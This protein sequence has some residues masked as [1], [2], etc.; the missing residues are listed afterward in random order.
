MNN[1][2]YDYPLTRNVFC[3]YYHTSLILNM[4]FF[5]NFSIR[6]LDSWIYT[7]SILNV[8][9]QELFDQEEYISVLFSSTELLLLWSQWR[10]SYRT[11]TNDYISGDKSRYIETNITRG[12]S[13][14]SPS[15]LQWVLHNTLG[16]NKRTW[17]QASKSN[18][19]HWKWFKRS[20]V[21][22]TQS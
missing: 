12:T 17:G 22:N 1:D 9:M 16:Y 18:G 2:D 4:P 10:H 14:C 3:S 21:F 19:S 8:K 7:P 15:G 5:S 11:G 20:L 13:Y 6:Y